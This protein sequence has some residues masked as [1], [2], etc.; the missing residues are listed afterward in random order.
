MAERIPREPSPAARELLRAFREH[1]SPSTAERDLGFAALRT[2]LEDSADEPSGAANGRFYGIAKATL[3]T[4][5]V[6]ATVLLAIKAVGSGVTALAD[7]ARQP[8]MEA[9]Y[10]GEAG[11]DGGQAVS[12]APR[13]LPR[14]GGAAPSDASVP[15]VPEVEVLAPEV[16]E[17]TVHD[18]P[19]PGDESS[20][21][22]RSSRPRPSAPASSATS[23]D[24]AVELAL[25][26][27][28]TEAK[29]QRRFDD[30]LAALREHAKRFQR[31]VLADE[32]MVLEAELHC[33]A[34]RVSKADALVER[35]LRE[36]A[37]SALTGRMRNV[38]RE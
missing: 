7:R 26:K 5:A 34:G 30:G 32:R 33:G 16:H 38:C 31:G 3:I 17:A 6:A 25:I 35:F 27:R 4:V 28:A 24:L 23:D 22:S 29:A 11:T 13:V 37:G 12:R 14:R 9:P 21:A 10:Q 18:E 8:A 20:S 15:T 2:R 19:S 36:R 1:E